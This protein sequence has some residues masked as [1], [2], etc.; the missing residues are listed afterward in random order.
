MMDETHKTPLRLYWHTFVPLAIILTLM[1]SYPIQIFLGES[2]AEVVFYGIIVIFCWIMMIW[3][4]IRFRMRAILLIMLIIWCST[5]A[6]WQVYDLGFARHPRSPALTYCRV[7]IC[8][9]FKPFEEHWAWY[10]PTK[11]DSSIMCH[12][13]FERYYGNQF[14]A[15]TLEIRR[16]ATWF[17][18]G[19]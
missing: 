4:W 5:L 19:G 9:D 11:Q 10:H 8:P 7:E 1:L 15:I 13:R 12:S 18:C 17:A 14:I 2:I 3:V 16:D 6:A